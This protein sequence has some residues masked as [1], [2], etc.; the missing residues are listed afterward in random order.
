MAPVSSTGHGESE[1]RDNAFFGAALPLL[2]LYP[3]LRQTGWAIIGA[4]GESRYQDGK[5]IPV[6][7]KSGMVGPSTRSKIDPEERISNQLH[8]LT[9]VTH[10]WRPGSVVCSWPGGMNWDGA[11]IHKLEGALHQWAGSLGLPVAG[12]SATEVR[13][14]IAGK[15]NASKDALAYAVMTRLNQIGE[16]RSAAEWEAIAAGYHHLQRQL[17]GA[18]QPNSS[19]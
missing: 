1:N 2:S 11:G 13:A 3:N 17:K 16:R 7:A 8:G 5:A 15:A 10:R 4:H 6:L 19:C 18:Q 12:Y 14:A 9:S